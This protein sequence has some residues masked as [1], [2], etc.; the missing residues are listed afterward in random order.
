MKRWEEKRRLK[1][2]KKKL[3]GMKSKINNGNVKKS[4]SAKRS[5]MKSFVN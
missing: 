3:R 5:K 1:A 2:H 4:M